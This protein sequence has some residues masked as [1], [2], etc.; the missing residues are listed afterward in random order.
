MRILWLCNI[1]LPKIAEARNQKQDA[2]GGWL[3]GLSN[4]LIINNEIALS[5]CFPE[6]DINN[7]EA[8]S[9]GKLEYYAFPQCSYN[10]PRGRFKLE[11]CLKEIVLRSKPDVINIHGTE[12][13]HALAMTTIC[14][15]LGLLNKVVVS[16]QGLV[17]VY[18]K[19][20]ESGLPNSV[21]HG[22]TIKELIRNNNIRKGREVF[23]RKGELEEQTIRNV[24]HV[25]GRTDWD[26][27]CIAQINPDAMYHFCNE[28]LRDSFYE[29]SWDIL[30]CKKYSIFISQA[31]YPIKGFHWMLEAMPEVVKWFPDAH[32]FVAGN[33]ITKHDTLSDKLRI[34]SYG[35]YIRLLINKYNL[36]DNVTFLGPLNEADM[37]KQYLASNVFVSASSIE[38][39]PNSVGEAMILGVPTISSDVGG[40][41]NMLTHN[42]EGFIYQHDA[43]YMLSYYIKKLFKDDNL[44]ETLS[45]NAR[46]QAKQ[47]HSRE[48]NLN[49]MIGI[50]EDIAR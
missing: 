43:P 49:A 1:M 39:S 15:K 13:P 29:H 17:S 20:Y 3:T 24:K 8:G 37:C 10:N 38:N 16:I 9:V 30:K 18:A 12:F 46:L 27:A 47:T 40:V 6:R 35:K 5:V 26:R 23:A 48:S 14:Q 33:D 28:T 7:V 31:G 44:A 45:R 41:K 42:V 21:A 19:H 22:H 36:K 4:S 11:S 2:Y 34:G 32:V 25:I 50:Y